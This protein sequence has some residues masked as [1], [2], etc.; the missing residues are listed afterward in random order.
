MGDFLDGVSPEPVIIPN[1]RAGER[2]PDAPPKRPRL[3]TSASQKTTPRKTKPVPPYQDH[4]ET[5]LGMYTTFAMAMMP[6]KPELAVTI[7]GPCRPPT[8][9][10]PDPPSV[11][12]NCV[13]AWDAAAKESPTVRRMLATL[14]TGGVIGS[15]I[16]A[17]VP[18]V[19]AAASG[20]KLAERLNPGDAME[21]W[22]RK[23]Q[24][25]EQQ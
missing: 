10:H 21:A 25:A 23:R 6:F 18:I 15:L 12:E 17:H 13:R 5:L 19:V 14:T 7:M 1:H 24:E 20:T 4:T 16:V 8:E 3:F 11:A 9:E 2:D 22:L